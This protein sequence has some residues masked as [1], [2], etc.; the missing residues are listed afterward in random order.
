MRVRTLIFVIGLAISCTPSG[1]PF[2]QVDRAD[3]RFAVTGGA[4]DT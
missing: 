2:Y 3:F 4:G 1:C